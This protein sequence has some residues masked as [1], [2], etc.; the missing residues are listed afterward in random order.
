MLGLKLLIGRDFLTLVSVK[1]SY[2]TLITQLYL[3]FTNIMLLRC[4]KVC[5]FHKH[6]DT[7]I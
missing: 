1:V 7:N 2:H 6:I 5:C 3:C 4:D